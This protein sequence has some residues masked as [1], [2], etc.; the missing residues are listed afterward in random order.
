MKI[1]RDYFLKKSDN[2]IEDFYSRPVKEYIKISLVFFDAIFNKFFPKINNFF[3]NYYNKKLAKKKNEN[4]KFFARTNHDFYE[5][6]IGNETRTCNIIKEN[7]EIIYYSNKKNDYFI[8]GISPLLELKNLKKTTSWSCKIFIFEHNKKK[9]LETIALDFPINF[10]NR[11]DNFVYHGKN[12]WIN[13]KIDLK[14]FRKK[15]LKIKIIAN[16][17]NSISNYLSIASPQFKKIKK[18]KKNIIIISMESLTD[19]NFLSKNYKFQIPKNFNNLIND[20][21]YYK[22]IYASCDS[23]LPYAA[24]LFSGLFPSQ[25]SIGDYSIGADTTNNKILNSKNFLIQKFL[26]EQEFQTF[27][28]GSA[29][30]FNSKLQFSKFFD[31]YFQLN[32][33]YENITLNINFL[34]K[35]LNS[36][37]IFDNFFLIHLDYLH[38]P[39]INFNEYEYISLK[40]ISLLQNNQEN[41]SQ[42]LYFNNIKK[43]DDEVGQLIN[44]LKKNDQYDETL[45]IIT[46]DHGSGINWDKNNINGDMAL[47]EERQRVPLIVKYPKW[48]DFRIKETNYPRN[49]ITEIFKIIF[50]CLNK[51]IPKTLKNLPQF[52]NLNNNFAITETIMNP[53]KSKTKHAMAFMNQHY[54]YIN[55]N[56]IDWNN[57]KIE[58]KISDKVFLWDEKKF[59]YNHNEDIKNKM[60]PNEYK[61]IKSQAYNL[62][63]ENLRFLKKNPSQSY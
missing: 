34:I 44:S 51:D 16:K 57:F 15:I 28:A 62:L 47:Y 41:L 8:F 4:A 9:L 39:L 50:G 24:S 23:T 30:R 43:M 26:K 7:Q 18:L 6:Q 61:K 17:N 13:I 33:N 58:K 25:H 3:S 56:Q 35:S 46:G 42:K 22:K 59:Q 14:K 49:S 12:G 54:K 60:L 21:S 19:L 31:H 53:G 37:E 2:Y 10:E 40:K 32:N 1:K 11:N 38:D 52:N 45:L 48:T 20:S 63:E 5:I 36:F 55:C 27:F 29:T